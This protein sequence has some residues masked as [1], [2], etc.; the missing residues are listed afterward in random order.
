MTPAVDL[1]DASDVA[2]QPACLKLPIVLMVP[3]R[4]I[5]VRVCSA[6]LQ[7]IEGQLGVVI[8]DRDELRHCVQELERRG[9]NTQLDDDIVQQVCRSY[10]VCPAREEA[11]HNMR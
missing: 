9:H 6:Q 8:A 10:S 5:C 4:L 3:A 1:V 2:Y 11:I 7:A